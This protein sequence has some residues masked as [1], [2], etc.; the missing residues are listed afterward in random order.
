[1]SATD[2]YAG[3]TGQGAGPTWM[4]LRL[5]RDNETIPYTVNNE[6]LAKMLYK[7]FQF[8]EIEYFITINSASISTG[9]TMGQIPL[10]TFTSQAQYHFPLSFIQQ[11]CIVV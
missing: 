4:E 5:Y 8:G 2:S 9:F 6:E 3:R 10:F 7:R 11:Q 1:M